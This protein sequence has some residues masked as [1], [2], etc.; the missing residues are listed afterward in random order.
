LSFF[1]DRI[2]EDLNRVDIEEE[3]K[4][5]KEEREAREKIVKQ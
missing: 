3:Q 2:S 4:K 5:Q 1:L